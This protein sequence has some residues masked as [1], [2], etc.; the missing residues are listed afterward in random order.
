MRSQ[1]WSKIR[2][3]IEAEG[4]VSSNLTEEIVFPT[5]DENQE[6]T[7][8]TPVFYVFRHSFIEVIKRCLDNSYNIIVFYETASGNIEKQ[9]TDGVETNETTLML[10]TN[11]M[12]G[13]P[14]KEHIYREGFYSKEG[15]S[16]RYI[17][18]DNVFL[19]KT[20]DF[21]AC[22]N[23]T[24]FST[25]TI[26]VPSA[27]S[28]T[29]NGKDVYVHSDQKE[30]AKFIINW[31]FEYSQ[32]ND[33][34]VIVITDIFKLHPTDEILDIVKTTAKKYTTIKAVLWCVN[35]SYNKDRYFTYKLSLE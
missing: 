26:K 27:D 34:Q 12:K 22:K 30:L 31:I 25:I 4:V 1:F 23:K 10:C 35:K 19:R 33:K 7:T 29:S 11:L 20:Q 5:N 21:S 14:G 15:N 9:L 32:K 16:W 24:S 13:Y 6:K 3:N 18:T 17:H 28:V 8:K 2:G